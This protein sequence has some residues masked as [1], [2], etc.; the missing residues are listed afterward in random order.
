MGRG[1]LIGHALL[2]AGWLMP[3]SPCDA[4]DATD[5]PERVRVQV[6]SPDEGSTV[7][8]RFDMIR[9]AG[10]AEAGAREAIFD[11]MLVVD[12]SGSTLYPSGIDVDGD[13]VLGVQEEA[14]IPGL[15]GTKNTDPEDSILGAEILAAVRL[16]GALDPARVRVGVV[17]FSGFVDP[18]SGKLRA[19][20]PSAL[21]E[22]P[23]TDD[24][25]AVSRALQAVQLRG[26]SGGTDMQ[27]GLKTAI[28]E[29]A[30]LE[31][32]VSEGRPGARRVILLLT[33]G[34]PSLPFGQVNVAD[35]EDIEATIAAGQLAAEAGILINVFGLGPGAINYPEAATRISQFTGGS[36]VP[37]RRPG[38][39]VTLLTGISF[40]EVAD[41]VAVNLTLGQ[42]SGPRDIELL[43][44]GSFRGFVPVRPGLN[45]IRVS[46][47][48]SDG[49]RGSTEFEVTY[50]LQDLSDTELRSE[51]ERVRNRNRD[52]QVLTE[53]RRQEASRRAERERALTLE[54]DGEDEQEDEE[55]KP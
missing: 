46:A 37:V 50:R 29:L 42:E 26:S 18:G 32:A 39:V 11:V 21:M 55:A 44:D 52:I 49:S 53:R 6:Q 20:Q 4:G 13:G 28:R 5:A 51:L 14:L 31:G 3:A 19:D 7:R 47:L 1:V 40:A 16:L 41:V 36:Y 12:V 24:Y 30:G 33:D 23:L 2:C 45:R 43:P 27:A 34:L 38:D 25:E 8:G 48:A 10:L 9:L 15:P 54:V 35:P 22:Q 17:S